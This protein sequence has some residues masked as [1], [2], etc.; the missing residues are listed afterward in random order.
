MSSD[1]TKVGRAWL[2]LFVASDT[3]PVYVAETFGVRTGDVLGLDDE[4]EQATRREK[5]ARVVPPAP[6]RPADIRDELRRV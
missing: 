2:D 4:R 1:E 5:C 6:S 3:G